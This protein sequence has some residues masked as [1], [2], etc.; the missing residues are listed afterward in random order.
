VPAL[1]P[2]HGWRVVA[3]P[4]A[5]DRAVWVGEDV[6]VVRFASDEAFGVGAAGV[7]LGDPDAI[8]EPETGFV[9]TRLTAAD[10]EHVLAH[11]EWPLPDRPGVLAQ[12]KIS[13]VPAKLLTGDP[14]LLVTQA[15]YAHELA[16]RLGW[17]G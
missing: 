8:M 17:L 2:L 3:S 11:V 6:T 9:G 12:G 15:A 13:G 16:H 5:L 1:E 7:R 4:E 10:L 14:A